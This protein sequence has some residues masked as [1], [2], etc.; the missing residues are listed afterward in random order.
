[1]ENCAHRDAVRGVTIVAVVSELL[2]H[3][4]LVLGFAVGASGFSFPSYLFEV[5]QTA[6]L[7]W[8]LLVNLYNVHGELVKNVVV[9]KL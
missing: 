9:N 3:W 6:F 7:C 2:F 4:S 1:M 8:K 5:L